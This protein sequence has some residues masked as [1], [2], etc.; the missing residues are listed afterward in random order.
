M[1]KKRIIAGVAGAVALATAAVIPASGAFGVSSATCE[2][3]QAQVGRAQAQEVAIEENSHLSPQQ[4]EMLIAGLNSR[5]S[6]LVAN[7]DRLGCE[8]APG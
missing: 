8:T 5:I 3:I 6:Q 4:K 7:G 1:K 2:R